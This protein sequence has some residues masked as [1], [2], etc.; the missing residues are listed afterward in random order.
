MGF[1]RSKGILTAGVA[2]TCLCLS[3]PTGGAGA[4]ELNINIH[5]QHTNVWCWAATIAMVSE[6]IDRFE[7][8]DCMVLAE[9][10]M[11]LGG[12]GMCCASPA[13]CN[14]AG[15]TTEMANILGIIFGIQGVYFKSPIG[16]DKIVE[17]IDA[18]Q[19]M[20]VGLSS[21]QSGHVVVISGYESPDKVVVLDPMYGRYTVDYQT[22]G[23]NWTYGVW[24][25]TFIIHSKRADK[26]TCQFVEE[27][28]P[29]MAPCMTQ[30]G[31]GMCPTTVQ[32]QR[33]LCE[34]RSAE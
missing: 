20:I 22:L 29:S 26:S 2:C 23:A 4:K 18:G 16:Y 7:L 12:Y 13:M 33:I 21:Q 28:L 6:Y 31:P 19:P 11:R 3:A 24:T 10:D 17:Q 14:R 34:P 27:S 1:T 32:R 15:Q 8:E 25:D 5:K 30:F 9:Y